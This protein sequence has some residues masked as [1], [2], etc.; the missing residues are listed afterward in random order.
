MLKICTD[1]TFIQMAG[2]TSRPAY[3]DMKLR[4][5]AHE[6]NRNDAVCENY[7]PEHTTIQGRAFKW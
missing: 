3:K 7:A 5:N 4:C 6:I 2:M 1:F